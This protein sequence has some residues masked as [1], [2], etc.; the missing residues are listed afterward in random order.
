MAIGNGNGNGRNGNAASNGGGPSGDPVDAAGAVAMLRRHGAAMLRQQADGRAR[1]LEVRVT[2]GCNARCA[3]CDAWRARGNDAEMPDYAPVV[4]RLGPLD[5]A[6]VG[7]EP[8]LRP[9]LDRLVASIRLG[10]E[11][12]SIILLTN[13]ADL[14]MERARRLHDAGVD[15]LV[16]SV[17]GLG[18]END[19]ARRRPGLFA[20]IDALFPG[21]VGL[22]FRT[23][24]LQ[25][26]IN[27]R[28]PA[29]LVD[30]ARYARD[31][32]LR[33]AYT[34]EGPSRL[35]ARS[36]A[37]DEKSLAALADAMEQIAGLAETWPHIASSP[38]YLRRVVPFL[39]EQTAGFPE[40]RAGTAFLRVTPDGWI[41]PCGSVPPMGHWTAWPLRPTAVDCPGCWSRLRGEGST[42]LG[43][44]RLVE[45]YRTSG[46]ATG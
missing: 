37:A 7:G 42:A 34:L 16:V 43:V 2:R 46:V 22:G 12:S 44:R 6:F 24:Q 39:R 28:E 30:A 33:I 13:G 45:L 5:V 32:G 14:T 27:G 21:L 10:T 36:L 19:R 23:V 25:V 3:W 31:R 38:E 15:K 9:D 11:V 41:H 17:E 26:T 20:H 40:C 8:L 35:E 18:E 4:R 1:L 29:Q